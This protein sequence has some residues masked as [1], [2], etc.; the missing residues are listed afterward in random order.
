MSLLDHFRPPLADHRDWHSFHNQWAAAIAAELNEV[1]PNDF[2]AEANVQYGIDIDIAAMEELEPTE[3]GL[4]TTRDWRP[5]Q[6]TLTIP[7]TVET[8]VAEVRVYRQI[9]GRILAAAIE[10]VSP[11][12]KDR[13]AHRNAFLAK[14]ES[15]LRRGIGLLMVD[16]VTNRGGNLD[17]ELLD[18]LQSPAELSN[19]ELYAAS[20]QPSGSNGT[21]QLAVWRRELRLGQPLPEIPLALR[22]G[23]QVRVALDRTYRK[24]CRE[25]RIKIPTG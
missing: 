15:Y 9:G 12:N 17:D 5:P 19:A 4:P 14:C 11:S 2:F 6:A 21:G 18:R 22:N 20:Y 13:E 23:P 10:L 24:V 7:F 25:L 1:L 16:V 3:F 8:D